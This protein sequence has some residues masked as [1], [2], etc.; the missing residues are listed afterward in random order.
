[1]GTGV[2]PSLWSPGKIRHKHLYGY[3]LWAAG[4]EMTS[5]GYLQHRQSIREI[6]NMVKPHGIL[7][8]VG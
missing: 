5:T 4:D 1:M 2:S 8:L 7:V 6:N 3:G